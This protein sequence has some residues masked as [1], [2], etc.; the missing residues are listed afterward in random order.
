MTDKPH[1]FTDSPGSVVIQLDK[2]L[3]PDGMTRPCPERGVAYLGFREPVVIPCGLRQF[4]DGPHAYHFE[5]TD[6]TR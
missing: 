3:S 4:H 2:M 5:W 6:V 1:D